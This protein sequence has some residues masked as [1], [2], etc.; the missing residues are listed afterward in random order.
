[1]KAY[2]VTATDAHTGYRKTILFANVS[3]Y[4]Y[5]APGAH[6]CGGASQVVTMAVHMNN[7]TEM[8]LRD[9]DCPAFEEAYL[10]WLQASDASAGDAHQQVLLLMGLVEKL[11]TATRAATRLHRSWEL[12]VLPPYVEEGEAVKE[13]RAGLA[14]A[15][16]SVADV[17][18]ALPNW[19]LSC[20]EDLQGLDELP[21]G[22]ECHECINVRAFYTDETGEHEMMCP[23]CGGVGF[24]NCFECRTPP[25]PCNECI[26]QGSVPQTSGSLCGHCLGSGEC[27]CRAC[28]AAYKEKHQP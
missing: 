6:R 10:A 9:A 11:R 22:H 17:E 13:F 2:F 1:V 24:C 26:G 27:K 28:R 8:S 14:S 12:M 5:M 23:H 7:G 15:D 20:M 4:V 3:H 18:Q 25:V 16:L 19:L 21:T